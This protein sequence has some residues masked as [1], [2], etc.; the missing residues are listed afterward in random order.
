[1][2]LYISPNRKKPISNFSIL[3]KLYNKRTGA[4]SSVREHSLLTMYVSHGYSDTFSIQFNHYR[5]TQPLKEVLRNRPKS[6]N[7]GKLEPFSVRPSGAMNEPTN[8][9][10][11]TG[12]HP[13]K[14]QN[15]FLHPIRHQFIE[16]KILTH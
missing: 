13:T 9:W 10:F 2:F 12:I 14:T 15:L 4:E 16:K 1:M 11:E 5:V 8:Y 6:E 7:D 3:L